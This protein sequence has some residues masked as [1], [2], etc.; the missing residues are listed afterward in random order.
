[1]TNSSHATW[2]TL[3][4]N[5]RASLLASLPPSS[6][7]PPHFLPPALP[8]TASV[9]HIPATCGLLSARQLAITD[10]ADPAFTLAK[11]RAGEWTASEVCEAFCGR[12]AVAQQLTGC[13][14]ESLGERA[15]RRARELDEHFKATGELVGP[16][17]G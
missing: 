2:Q 8:P 16:L 11:L 14:T 9:L 1:M 4:A 17:H 7:L 15:G 12:A 13:L 3:A 10:Y 6:L 5:K